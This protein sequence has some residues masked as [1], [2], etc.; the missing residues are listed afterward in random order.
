MECMD[1]WDPPGE[2]TLHIPHSTQPKIRGKGAGQKNV[3]GEIIHHLCQRFRDAHYEEA[4]GPRVVCSQLHYLCS[5]WLEPKRRTKAEMLDL[6]VLE[7]F[8]AVLPPKM[9][10][11][12]RECGAETSSQAVALVEGFLLG[13]EEEKKQEEMQSQGPLVEMIAECPK[14]TGHFSQEQLLREVSQEDPG[15]NTLSGNRTSLVFVELSPPDS[16]RETTPVLPALC[17]VSFEEVAVYFSEEEWALMD[18]EQRALHGEV[19]LEN[20]RNMTSL[21]ADEQADKNEEETRML[22][23]Q[24]IKQEA[25]EEVFQYPPDLKRPENHQSSD[26]E[27]PS[28]QSAGIL[29]SLTQEHW[30]ESETNHFLMCGEIV[31]DEPDLSNHYRIHMEGQLCEYGQHP[32]SPEV[33]VRLYQSV[34]AEKKQY[35]CKECGKHFCDSHSLMRHERIHTGEKPYKCTECGQ[36]F[37][38]SSNLVSHKRI[39]TG[40]KPF[41]CTQ[42]GKSFRRSTSLTYHERNHTGVK[43]YKC[44][45]CGKDFCDSHSLTRHKKIHSGEKPFKCTECGKSFSQSTYLTY[46]KMIHTGEKPYQCKICG[47]SFIMSSSLT[48]HQRIHTGEK[49]YKCLE[50]GK[51]FLQSCHLTSHKRIHTGEKPY[52]CKECGKDFCDSHSL[53]RH[54]RIHTGEKPY[55]CMVCGKGFR[56]GSSLTDHE[57]I[58]T[59]EKPYQCTE[60]GKSFTHSGHL[61]SHKSIHGGETI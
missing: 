51:S 61:S 12:V 47:K 36:S 57:R 45:E 44:M 49:P 3:V 40:E 46:H 50:C 17:P 10:S 27:K 22:S 26:P 32:M 9:E 4:K 5:Q 8:L 15:Q 13:Q 56:R 1:L 30:K 60:C 24:T 19:M 2:G 48:Y 59:G 33:S 21:G 28:S 53:I 58:H 38:Q 31:K 20:S 35:V 16:G 42:C 6:V 52:K 39:H 14:A 37:S 11:W 54:E 25:Q 29:D 7:Q 18:S 23:L 41:T 43:P 55:Q 34:A